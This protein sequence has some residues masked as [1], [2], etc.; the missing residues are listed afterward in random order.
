MSP[1]RPVGLGRERPPGRA[2]GISV[3]VV[4]TM[5]FPVCVGERR[6][7]LAAVHRMGVRV[8]G[9]SGGVYRTGRLLR[10]FAR[11]RL[12][13]AGFGYEREAT[14]SRTLALIASGIGA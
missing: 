1:R 7:P 4:E 14:V 13:R 9:R 3:C 12:C 5:V 2:G 8:A 11:L 6:A 10:V